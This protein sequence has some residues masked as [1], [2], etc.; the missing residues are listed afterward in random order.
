LAAALS[1]LAVPPVDVPPLQDANN[2]IA[3]HK[4]RIFFIVNGLKSLIWN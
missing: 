2:A 3:A 4:Y 1:V